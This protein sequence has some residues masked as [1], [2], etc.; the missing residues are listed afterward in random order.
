M[1]TIVAL[2]GLF[3]AMSTS[4]MAGELPV[5]RY[6]QA[7][8][9]TNSVFSLPIAIAEREKLFAREGLDF[10]VVIPNPGG[11][12]RMIHALHD[13]SF[14]VNAR[15]IVTLIGANGAGKSTTLLALSGL[16]APTSGSS[17]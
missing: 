13:V 7:F 11:A 9:A 5:L 12:D 2:A 4:V 3:A 16:L 6:G 10:R 17:R 14:E 15:E 1:R 8:S